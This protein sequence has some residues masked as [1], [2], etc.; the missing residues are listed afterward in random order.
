MEM[1]RLIVNL[2]AFTKC[3]YREQVTNDEYAL[4]HS[5]SLVLSQCVLESHVTNTC[6]LIIT[7]GFLS[8]IKH[9]YYGCV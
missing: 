6:R 5:A 1:K 2:N 7:F 8:T 3:R 4:R 9:N